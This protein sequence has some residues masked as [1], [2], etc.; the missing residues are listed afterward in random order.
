[1]SKVL[2]LTL[3]LIIFFNAQQ[4]IENGLKKNFFFFLALLFE[5]LR[6]ENNIFSDS[7]GCVV[8]VAK[9]I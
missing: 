9:L 1:M 5:I 6:V 4:I 3:S 8:V 2:Q 7:L